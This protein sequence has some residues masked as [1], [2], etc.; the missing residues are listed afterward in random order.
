MHIEAELD[1]ETSENAGAGG[2][3][4]VVSLTDEA[5]ND[6]TDKVD[7]GR[8]FPSLK[9]LE[10]ELTTVFGKEVTVEEV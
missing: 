5:G 10:S 8:H 2:T 6:V 4:Q 9:D 1:W 3:F 7:Q